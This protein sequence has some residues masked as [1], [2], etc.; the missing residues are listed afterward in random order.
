LCSSKIKICGIKNIHTLDCCI[1]NKINF[2]GLIF[3][4]KSPRYIAYNESL[5]LIE[6]SKNK[7][8]NSVGVFVNEKRNFL[9]ELTKNLKLD[10]LQ[11]H[12]QEDNEYIKYI[13]R[14]NEIKII[15][16]ISIKSHE[17]I[18]KIKNFP[19]T[20]FFLFDYKPNPD[21]MPGGNSKKFD[22]G[23]LKNLKLEKKWFLSG[24]INIDNIKD[25]KDYTIPYGI[26]IS[27]G[28]EDKPGIKNNNKIKL[29]VEKYESV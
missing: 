29:L 4:K 22:W 16:V 6:Y 2:Y 20:D 3:Y 25:I 17:D 27:S 18:K 28:V 23:I 5:P 14:Y 13:K 21:E 24:G 11:L 26:D 9:C 7:N 10:Y 1:E 12:G 8:I 15:K 19:D